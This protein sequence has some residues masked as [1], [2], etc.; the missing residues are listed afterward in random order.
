MTLREV[1]EGYGI[2]IEDEKLKVLEDFARFLWKSPVN[3]TSL[4]GE[5]LY[6]KG[7][8]EVLY[9]LKEF[10]I[11]ER[12]V[13]VG[14][15]GGI[16]GIVWS[17]YFGVEGVLVDSRRKKIDMVKRFIEEHSL[18]LEAI[19]G[20]AEEVVRDMRESFMYATAK[21][22]AKTCEAAELLAP[23]VQVGGYVLLYKGPSWREEI[24]GCWELL[25]EMGLDHADTIEYELLRGERRA[26]VILEKFKSTPRRFPRRRRRGR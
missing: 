22:L 23:F 17:V 19:W 3:L 13:D 26:L 1:L 11:L 2:E 16:P 14:T 5:E 21:A 24:E 15:G 4:E 20:R 18:P 7:I 9:P 8:A 10:P 12:F 25:E 6:H